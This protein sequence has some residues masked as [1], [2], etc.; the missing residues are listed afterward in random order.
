[1]AGDGQ[2]QIHQ[3][4]KLCPI[5]VEDALAQIEE[6]EGRHDADDPEDRLLYVISRTV[7][8]TSPATLSTEASSG[9]DSSTL[10]AA[11]RPLL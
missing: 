8:D 10:Q 3:C 5:E 1:V 4:L 9:S 6:D 7:R 11:A 2:L